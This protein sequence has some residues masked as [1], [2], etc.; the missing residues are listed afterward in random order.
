MRPSTCRT[1]PSHSLVR[2]HEPKLTAPAKLIQHVSTSAILPGTQWTIS[3]RRSVKRKA[4]G[5]YAADLALQL[6]VRGS[7]SAAFRFQ[8]DRYYLLPAHAIARGY[9]KSVPGQA[10][11]TEETAQGVLETVGGSSQGT[12]AL[13]FPL[14]ITLSFLIDACNRRGPRIFLRFNRTT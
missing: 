10:Q 12:A 5:R 7:G 1:G 3:A 6:P 9:G 8:L 4:G 11:A 2:S 14:T 13:R